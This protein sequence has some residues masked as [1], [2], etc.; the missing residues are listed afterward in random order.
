MNYQ[1]IHKSPLIVGLLAAVIFCAMMMVFSGMGLL[2]LIPVFVGALPIYVA[3]LGWGTRAGVV[4]TLAIIAVTTIIS[5]PASGLLIGMMI[6]APAALAGHQANLAQP[7]ASGS[8]ELQWYPLSRILFWITLLIIAAVLV[9][10]IMLDFDPAEIAPKIATQL[11]PLLPPLENNRELSIDDIVKVFELNLQILPFVLPSLWI[12][13]HF[14]NL[15]LAMTI[16]RRMNVLARPVEDIAAAIN[17]PQST[18]VLLV[19]SLTGTAITSQPFNYGFAVAAGGLV[20]AF[21]IVGLAIMH[22]H[23]RGWST[24]API[25]FL[26]YAMITLIFFPVY[27]FSFVGLLKVAGSRNLNRNLNSDDNK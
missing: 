21:S 20:M 19:V 1:L 4:A 12:G 2:V 13:I 26:T 18:L 22:Q 11:K 25:L 9:F 14:L 27:L 16:T 7:D 17:L 24:R 23:I 5:E 6:A 3:T 10:G 15:L 8:G